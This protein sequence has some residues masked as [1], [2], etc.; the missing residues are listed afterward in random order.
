MVHQKKK[1]KVRKK[2][3]KTEI[4]NGHR[5]VTAPTT[6][7]EEI[8]IL[9]PLEKLFIER[10]LES[11]NRTKAIVEAGY[12]G[13]D[14]KKAAYRLMQK[15][16]VRRVY[17]SRLDEVKRETGVNPEM[18]VRELWRIATSS[19]A[20]VLE[21]TEDGA[22]RMKCELSDLPVDVRSGI[23]SLAIGKQ[24]IQ[25]RMHNKVEALTTL[26]RILLSGERGDHQDPEIT[27]EDF[28]K[29]SPD[30]VIEYV[31]RGLLARATSARTNRH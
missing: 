12:T 24:G 22:V 27:L 29:L 18:V 1:P 10:L 5:T 20:D 7:A 3:A 14:P 23:R 25:I 13:A 26:A 15:H 6:A 21:T 2:S 9:S 16:A 17:N 11:G 31:N 28:S 19:I 30:E 4:A 8:E